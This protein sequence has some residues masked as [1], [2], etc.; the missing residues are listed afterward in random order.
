M[1]GGWGERRPCI[2][3][4]VGNE[5]SWKDDKIGNSESVLVMRL[6]VWATPITGV[7]CEQSSRCKRIITLYPSN[8]TELQIGKKS[9]YHFPS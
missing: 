6:Q 5:M 7:L 4:L 9:L 3:T 2:H 8:L 1:E